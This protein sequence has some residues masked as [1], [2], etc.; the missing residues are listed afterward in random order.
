MSD[1]EKDLIDIEEG[2][3]LVPSTEEMLRELSRRREAK[4]LSSHD[5][6]LNFIFQLNQIGAPLTRRDL[7]HT[8]GIQAVVVTRDDLEALG[9]LDFIHYSGERRLI[10]PESLQKGSVLVLYPEDLGDMER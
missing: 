6:D 2:A 9:G 5:F 4:E 10:D 3:Q 1:L 8:T 7:D